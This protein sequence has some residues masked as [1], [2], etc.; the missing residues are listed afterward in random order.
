MK[1]PNSSQYALV[2][3]VKSGF[4]R[5]VPDSMKIL[6]AR[7][8][9]LVY[10]PFGQSNMHNTLDFCPRPVRNESNVLPKQKRSVFHLP[11]LTDLTVTGTYPQVG[12]QVKKN[13][14]T[15]PC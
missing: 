15:N 3:Q 2:I 6:A 12:T 1:A 11:F 10:E 4:F 5:S 9:K 7:Y 8:L 14:T 13:I